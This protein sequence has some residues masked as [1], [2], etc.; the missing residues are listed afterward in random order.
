VPQALGDHTP[1]LIVPA[2]LKETV[3]PIIIRPR[4]NDFFCI[5]NTFY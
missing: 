5:A 4:K 3:D 2:I 1:L